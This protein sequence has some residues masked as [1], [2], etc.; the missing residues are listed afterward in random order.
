[1]KRGKELFG[2]KLK[3]KKEFSLDDDEKTVRPFAM[4]EIGNYKCSVAYDSPVTIGKVHSIGRRSAQQDS[5]GISDVQNRELMKEKGLLAIVADG[6]GGMENG[7]EISKIVTVSMLRYFDEVPF[8]ETQDKELIKMLYKAN[9]DVNGFLGRDGLG[10]SGSTL[11]AAILKE[12][13]VNWIS[14][15]DSCIYVYSEGNLKQINEKHVY[16][17]E[18]EEK[19]KI[20]KLTSNQ[21]ANDPQRD[22]LTSYIGAG[23]IALIDNNQVPLELTPGDRLLLMSDGIF[24]TISDEEIC[25][26]MQFEVD[27]AAMKMKYLIESK[28]KDNQDNFTALIIEYL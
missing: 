26:L 11:V 24:G 23:E 16:A 1:M 20:G 10:R 28:D 9:E 13:N 6:M 19:V 3:K 8:S 25:E 22:A 27:E 17:A 18:L 2:F 12:G 15:G 21:A 4:D 5:F 7:D 14:V